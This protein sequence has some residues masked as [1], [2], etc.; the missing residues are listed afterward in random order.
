MREQFGGN[1]FW[2][3]CKIKL[4]KKEQERRIIAEREK[5]FE[6]ARKKKEV[7]YL[8]KLEFY[9]IKVK[10]MNEQYNKK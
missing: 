1:R 6:R 5:F 2:R 4:E 8:D 10:E 9:E 7:D 3:K